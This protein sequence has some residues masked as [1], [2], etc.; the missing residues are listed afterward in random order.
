MTTET[1]TSFDQL[2]LSQPILKV[3]DD[4]GYEI[5]SPIQAKT[6]PLIAQGRDV[7]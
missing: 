6:I 5:P 3:L 1:V 2:A 4:V 7:L